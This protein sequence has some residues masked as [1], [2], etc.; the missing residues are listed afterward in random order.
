MEEINKSPT[1]EV[2]VSITL[3]KTFTIKVEDYESLQWAVENQVILPNNAHY[4]IQDKPI[5][6]QALKDLK[7]WHVDDFA[8]VLETK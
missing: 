1:K 7:D 6:R 8:V 4:Y 2:T 3:S 5:T